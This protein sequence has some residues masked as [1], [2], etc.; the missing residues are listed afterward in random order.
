MRMFYRFT[1]LSFKISSHLYNESL[2]SRIV[3][4]LINK[5]FLFSVCED[6]SK[7]EIILSTENLILPAFS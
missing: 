3:L 4:S 1:N 6:S 2:R 7:S 5:I